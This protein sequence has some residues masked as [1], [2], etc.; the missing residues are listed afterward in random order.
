MWQAFLRPRSADELVTF[1]SLR[2]AVG[3]YVAGLIVSFLLF[4]FAWPYW[5][6]ADMDLWM[7]Y[8]GFL[9]GDHQHQDF[10]DHPGYLSFLLLGEWMRALHALGLITI[11][12]L[13]AL[14]PPAE[15]GEAWTEAIR[16]GRVLSLILGVGLVVSFA[17][18]LRRLLRNWRMAALGTFFL[19][20]SGGMAM[21]I[22]V[23]RTE[24]IAAGLMALVLVLLL[25]AARKY[26]RWWRPFIVGLAALLAVLAMLNKI[27]VIFLICALPA[28]VLTFGVPASEQGGADFWRS[29]RA[30]LGVAAASVLVAA[31]LLIPAAPL[32][33]FGIANAGISG[34]AWR[35]VAFGVY[36]FY[37]PLIALWLIAAVLAF[38][39]LYRVGA[40]ETVT[41]LAAMTAGACLGLLT[42][43]IAYEPRDVIVV[44]NPLEQMAHMTVYEVLA[45]KGNLLS[46]QFFA[47][48]FQG[49]GELIAR[50]TFVLSSSPRPTIFLEWAVIA[51]TI[52]AFRRGRTQLA[53]QA[54]ALLT[55]GWAIDLFGV[56]R[57]LKQEYFLFT[58]P[59][60]IVAAVWLL[61]N[62]SELRT[63]RWAY[64]IGVVLIGAH[65]A[66][67]QAEPIKHTL[68]RERSLEFCAPH[69]YYTPRIESFS[70]CT[71]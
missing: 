4:G 57:G 20:F 18:L 66:F 46:P 71:Q 55:A 5:R 24:L 33:A 23:L 6:V 30:P 61:D 29:G 17:V 22:R 15:A 28:V 25:I 27:Q 59:L 65:I 56:L 60:V 42:L 58:D 2:T 38:A 1:A 11:D 69:G 50:R 19:A 32:A 3:V 16:A 52:V 47:D 9:F 51:M 41:T 37:Q 8:G 63:Y 31:L 68:K 10:F 40:L 26:R 70:Y 44:M 14:P 62:V 13:S 43:E 39:R 35:P 53:L 21:Q 34:F 45:G 54:A 7:A 49:L 67:S 36:G 12:R 48:L 64:Q